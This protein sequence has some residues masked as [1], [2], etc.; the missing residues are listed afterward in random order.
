VS[1]SSASS[2]RVR[3]GAAPSRTTARAAEGYAGPQALGAD[4]SLHEWSLVWSPDG[5][6]VAV[7]RDGVALALIAR[8]ARPGYSKLLAQSGPWGQVWDE[9]VF[10]EVMG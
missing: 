5:E 1:Y 9:E 2:I 6:S 8:A 10:R 3:G 4:P 7:L